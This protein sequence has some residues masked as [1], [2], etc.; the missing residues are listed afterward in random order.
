MG[1]NDSKVNLLERLVQHASATARFSVY[2][3]EGRDFYDLRGRT[4]HECVFNT[5][6][7]RFRCPSTQQGY[8]PFSTWTRGLAWA[9]CGFAEQLEFL[10]TLDDAELAEEWGGRA[11]ITAMM[12]KA[13]EATCD[14]YLAN[15]AA[16]GIPYWDTGSPNLHQLGEWR[17]RPSDPFNEHE[18]VDSSAAAIG[19][20]GLLR[21]GA[22][23][24]SRGETAA[25][26]RY[27]NAGI[28]VADSLL[29]EPYLSTDEKH[30]GLLLHAV[31]HRPN[32]W[33]AMPAGST[34][35]RNESCMWGDYHLRELALYLE[36]VLAG[37]PYLTFWS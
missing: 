37:G 21:L 24:N 25:A 4:V 33:D 26:E 18:P 17:A 2:Y 6:D 10:D 5:N 16:D 29:A 35:P 11:G 30:Q 34:V 22:W 32:G 15:T 8:S 28:Q 23:L 14:F 1:E 3:G 12:R 7:G 27:W 9:M 31:Y 20:Q 19:A 13:A 36:R